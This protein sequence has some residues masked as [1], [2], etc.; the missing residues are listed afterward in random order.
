MNVNLK[1]N[2][3]LEE[4]MLIILMII[5]PFIDLLNG[6]FEFVLNVN[7][8]PGVIIRSC[9][10]IFIIYFY[11]KEEKLNFIIL[12]FIVSIF[13]LQMLIIS[14]SNNF[15]ILSEISFISKIY[16]NLF[17]IFLTGSV[18]SKKDINYDVYFNCFSKV[19]IIVTLS[20]VIT[21]ILGIGINSYGISGGYKGLYMG[22]NDLTAVLVM[23]L[24]FMLY[25]IF[26][27]GTNIIFVIIALL[28]ALNMIMIGTKT[29]IIFLIIISLFFLYNIFFKNINLKSFILLILFLGTF[30]IVFDKY[31]FD[32]FKDTILQRQIYFIKE[33]DL[34]SYLL[35]ER[36]ITLI[37]SIRFWSSSIINIILGASFNNGAE[38]I[39]NFSQGHGMIEMD[40]IDIL[41]FYGIILFLIVA[42]PLTKVLIKGF[43][44]LFVKK[45]LKLKL[46]AFI[47]IVIFIMSFLGG[48]VLLSPLAGV[49]FAVIYG[50]LK[51]IN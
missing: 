34:V 48:H 31:L 4:K 38:F 15:N 22:T 37:K 8:S 23:T 41:Y 45:E 44:V 5:T 3:V 29:A 13:L 11:I 20:L 24:P 18:L 2:K 16:Y 28:A 7:L 19:C 10:L 42:Y 1:Y 39:G 32:I 50:I 43:K 46:I 25:R 27:D 14:F 30:L 33:N 26:T 6:F 36:N 12:T 21:K 49:Y 40:L 9:I 35:S 17:L 51:N 47:Y